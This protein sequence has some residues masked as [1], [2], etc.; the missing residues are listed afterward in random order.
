MSATVVYYPNEYISLVKGLKAR[1]AAG[2]PGVASNIHIGVST[3]F[4]KIC[5]CVLQVCAMRRC[6]APRV[7]RSA[8][9]QLPRR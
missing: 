1:V 5:G 6:D 9:L 8:T 2:R 3:N 7:F 4:D